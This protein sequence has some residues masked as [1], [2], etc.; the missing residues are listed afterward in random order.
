MAGG[1]SIVEADLTNGEHQ[2][3][4]V[5]LL[6]MYARD[7][8]G[9]RRALSD[10]ARS[11]LVAG[12]ADHPTSMVFLAFDDG[13]PAGIVVCF[14][15]FSTFVAKRLLN[16]HDVAV[17]PDRRGRGVGRRLLER[18]ESKARELGCCKLTLE[19]REDNDRA[20]R[21]YRSIGFDG[22]D[23]THVFFTKSL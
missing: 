5:D 3:A 22:G 18:V 17:R 4:I 11:G 23:L 15:G 14:M 19:V 12:L 7:G 2:R 6:D 1:I 16:I 13:A 21:L 10:E 8:F 20:Q 9:N